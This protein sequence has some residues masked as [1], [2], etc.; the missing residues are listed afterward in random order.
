[1]RYRLRILLGLALATLAADQATKFLAVTRLTSALEGRE[2]VRTR[3]RGFFTEHNLDGDP[4][5]VD[6]RDHTRGRAVEVVE[7]LWALRYMENPG[8]AFGV[9]E[10]LPERVR[11]PLLHGLSLLGLGFILW[12]FFWLDDA[13]RLS[14]A[15]L[16]LVL[17]GALGNFVDRVV[18]GYVIDVIDLHWRSRPDLHWPTFNLADAGI[19]VGA[20]LLLLEP[21]R[22][23]TTGRRERLDV[24]PEVR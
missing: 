8:V 19:C 11:T 18:H 13:Q 7:G 21:L 6:A 20:A 23:T 9:L 14:Q 2:G 4:P 17:G 10:N 1:M 3:V 22:L 12:M 24:A 5:R 16:S 15:A